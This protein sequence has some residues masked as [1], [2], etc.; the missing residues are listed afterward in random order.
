[1]GLVARSTTAPG[2]KARRKFALLKMLK[3]AD[4]SWPLRINDTMDA[5]ER[6]FDLRESVS[7]CT[8]RYCNVTAAIPFHLTTSNA[9]NIPN[10]TVTVP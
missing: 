3:P 10:D 1:M 6:V 9:T 4:E 8:L 7:Q 5:S 2:V